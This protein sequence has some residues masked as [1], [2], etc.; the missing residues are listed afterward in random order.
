MGTCYNYRLMPLSTIFLYDFGTVPTVLFFFKFN[1]IY[2]LIFLI[3]FFAFH[4][5]S[6]C[7]LKSYLYYK[8][9]VE[10]RVLRFCHIVSL[11]LVQNTI[12]VMYLLLFF[13]DL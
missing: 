10:R 7:L 2:F 9:L 12:K 11:F 6:S 4:L 8:N 13:F 5:T 3:I 1:L